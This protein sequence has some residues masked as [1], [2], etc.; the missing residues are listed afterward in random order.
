MST[1][2]YAGTVWLGVFV[3]ALIAEIISL[4]LTSIWFC[5]GALVSSLLGFLGCNIYIQVIAFLLVS[6]VLILFLRPLAKNKLLAHS[7]PT[8]IDELIGK[9][10]KVIER[11][12]PSADTG[13]V[14]IGD[15]EWRAVSE[16]GAV[17]EAGSK[18]SIVRIEGTK[19]IVR[20]PEGMF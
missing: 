14:K 6:T 9:E 4:G 20:W 19:V 12:D 13:H 15:V 10:V 7:H 18:V 5:G 16:H 3:I 17:F 11:I 1:A 8:N 2:V